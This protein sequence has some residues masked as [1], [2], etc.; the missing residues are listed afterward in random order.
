MACVKSLG[1]LLLLS[2]FFTLNSATLVYRK[3]EK[4]HPKKNYVQVVEV[5]QTRQE[6]P[7]YSENEKDLNDFLAQDAYKSDMNCTKMNESESETLRPPITRPITSTRL[8]VTRPITTTLRPMTK[9]TVT[10][11]PTIPTT[12]Y[13][14]TTNPTTRHTSTPNLNNLFTIRMTKPTIKPNP[15]ENTNPDYTNLLPERRPNVQ[16]TKHP[17]T[18][19]PTTIVIKETD[20]YPKATE[21]STTELW[22]DEIVYP[23]SD[24][25]PLE[26]DDDY[27]ENNY[28]DIIPTDQIDQNKPT[29]DLEVYSDGEGYEEEG[30]DEDGD[31]ETR[32]YNELRKRR[33]RRKIKR[34]APLPANT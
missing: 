4:K 23:N 7:H 8:P 1:I 9:P 31:E 33:K 2:V 21:S 27:D 15:K 19:M 13:R 24:E 29:E 6:P 26:E 25:E 22:D 28:P 30:D 32:D 3:Y 11:F 18:T 20:E 10:T 16:M 12:A 34:V 5:F 14:Q 17:S